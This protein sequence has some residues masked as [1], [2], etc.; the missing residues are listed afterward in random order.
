MYFSLCA[1]HNQE[2]IRGGYM[3]TKLGKTILVSLAS[4]SLF[5][6]AGCRGQE[7]KEPDQQLSVEDCAIEHE[8]EFGGIYIKIPIDDFNSLGF[9]Y[10]DSVDVEFTNGFKLTD[11]PYYNGY[12]VDAGET[13]LIAYPGYDY[14][15]AAVNYGDDLW[16][17]G[18][19]QAVEQNSLWLMSKADEH[20]KASVRLHE[21]GKYLDIQQARDIHYKDDRTLFPSDEAFA[22]FRA[23]GT[24]NIRK[25]TLYR[26]ASPCDNQHQRAPFVNDLIEEAGVQ[27]ILDL[28][29]NDT[30]IKKYIATDDF[31]SPYFLSLYENEK[32][33]PLALNMNY[34]SDDF[35]VTLAQ[36]FVRMSEMEGPYLVHCTEGKDRTGFVCMLMEALAGADYAS[37]R[38]DYM[39][40]YANYYEIDEQSD[41]PKYDVILDKNLNAM[42]RSIVND[43][44]VD[45]ETADL[46]VYARKYLKDGGM[47]DEEIET[48]LNCFTE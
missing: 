24:K 28:A 12:Y 34:M 14:I 10:G 23:V 41:K 44:S 26:S 3:K 13:L 27:C 22:N 45:I 30:K 39:V 6:A 4:L 47:S 33:I 15:K 9:S 5:T 21:K 35:R 46:S 17:T 11:I 2:K 36:G 29:D 40:T 20:D 43:D 31:D 32:V 19:L 48:F 37:I 8:M 42:I 16:D 1:Y 18:N 25:N 7:E 38:D